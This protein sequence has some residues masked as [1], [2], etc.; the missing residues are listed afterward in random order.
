M[1]NA[2]ELFYQV[3]ILFGE[4]LDIVA[5]SYKII[6]KGKTK[7]FVTKN[8]GI[9]KNNFRWYFFNKF[10]LG[11]GRCIMRKE[12][13]RANPY[14]ESLSRFEDMEYALRIL[15]GLKVFVIPN[16]IFEYQ[17][18]NNALSKACS[19]KHKDF[20]FQMVFRKKN[21]WAKCKMGELLMLA[22]TTYPNE[23]WNL[24]LHYRFNIAYAVI[25]KIKT[26][27][28]RRRWKKLFSF[29]CRSY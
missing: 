2:L 19:D 21:F 28:N 27:F 8:Y 15:D 17:C 13:L 20:T 24:L 9:V 11:P 14:D 12:I 3:L 16:L 18:D 26:S 25:A 22:F 7:L 23:R 1:P 4:Q 10:Y 6:N 29:C 5:G